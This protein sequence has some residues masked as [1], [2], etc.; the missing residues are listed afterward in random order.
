[1]TTTAT[2]LSRPP[3]VWVLTGHKA[4]DNTQVLA[5]AEALGWPFEVRRMAYHRYE[6]L[7]NR[8]F[9]TTLAGLDKSAS[10]ELAPPWPDLLITAGRRNE[11]VARWVRE[12]SGG[13]T[14]LVHLGRPWSRPDVF[15][16]IVVTPQYSVPRCSNVLYVNLPLHSLTRARLDA[17]AAGWAAQLDDLQ[18]PYWTVLLGGDSGPFVLTGEKLRQLAGWLNREVGSAGGSLLVSNS[19]RT[20]D[21]LYRKFLGRLTVPVHAWHWG[22][23]TTENPYQAFLGLADHLVVSGESMSMLAEAGATGKPL[24]IFDLSDRPEVP[25]DSAAAGKFK[26]PR[27]GYRPL[28]HALAT[29]LGPARM[30]RDVTRLQAHLVDSGHAVWAGQ[31]WDRERQPATEDD[32]ASAANRVRELFGNPCE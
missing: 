4:G 3:R 20:P 13:M 22:D 28:I 15:D 23:R 5:L 2:D 26:W 7:T 6:L 1:M 21:P 25:L 8:L 14:R 31:A 32:L 30:R 27:L 19:A 29:R 18:R 10:S 12:Q 16:L 9:G 11:P 17:A 24:H